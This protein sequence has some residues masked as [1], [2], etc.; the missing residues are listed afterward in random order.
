MNQPKALLLLA[1]LL[2]AT[3]HADDALTVAVASNF[4]GTA[5]EVARTFTHKTGVPVLLSSGSTGKL[6]AQI[7]NGAP[8]DIFLAADIK[9]PQMLEESG[10]AVKGSMLTY[11]KGRLVLISADRSLE[12]QTCSGLLNSGSYRKIAIAN[13]ETAPYGAA[14]KA[15]L[16]TAGLWEDAKSRMVIGENILQTFQ[17]VATGNATLGF[18]AASQLAVD[19]SPT[20]ISCRSEID[21][22]ETDVVYQAAIILERTKY[23]DDARSFMSFLQSAEARALMSSQGYEAA[24]N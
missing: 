17:F 19:S 23:L 13:P 18:V 21:V 22:P 20:G 16:Q 12:D 3:T 10:V 11:A 14:A 8:F 5:E 24:P 1:V 9:R 2:T 15:Y 4:R 6:Y 7:V